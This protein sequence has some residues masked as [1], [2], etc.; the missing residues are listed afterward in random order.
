MAFIYENSALQQTKSYLKQNQNFGKADKG[1]ITEKCHFNQFFG[2]SYFCSRCLKM[3][4][5]WMKLHYFMKT[6]HLNK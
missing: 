5:N 1:G 4:I 3:V 6:A 2:I